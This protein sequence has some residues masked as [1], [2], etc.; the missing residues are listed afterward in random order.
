[1]SLCKED[2]T[3]PLDS[4]DTKCFG[5]ENWLQEYLDL[6]LMEDGAMTLQKLDGEPEGSWTVV[7][8]FF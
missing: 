1:M 8:S 3:H 7:S 2:D 6:T 5:L 4:K